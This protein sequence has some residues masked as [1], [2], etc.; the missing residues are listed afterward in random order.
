MPWYGFKRPR[1]ARAMVACDHCQRTFPFGAQAIKSCYAGDG[2]WLCLRCYDTVPHDELLP[3]RQ[4]EE[5]E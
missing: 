5:T 4:R 1:Q 2:H 3:P